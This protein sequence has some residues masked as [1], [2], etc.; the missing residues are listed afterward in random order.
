M[1]SIDRRVNRLE[2]RLGITLSAP[3]YLLLLMRAGQELGPA[4]DAYINS[5]DEAGLLPTSGFG[6]VDLSRGAQ[7]SGVEGDGNRAGL[8]FEIKLEK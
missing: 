3:R 7:H 8:S 6:M 5:L 4:D 1:R 2:H